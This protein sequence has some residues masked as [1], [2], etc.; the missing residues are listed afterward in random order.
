M[1]I[2]NLAQFL[3]LVSGRLMC[4]P[5]VSQQ[6]G[7]ANPQPRPELAAEYNF[8]NS[9]APPGGCGC[10]N[11]NGGS[12]TFAWPLGAGSFSLLGDVGVSHAGSITSSGYGLTLSTFTVG[13]RYALRLAHSRFLPYGQ[14][15]AGVAHA[16]GTL[17]AGSNPGATNAG[18]AF[19]GIAGGGVDF[20]ASRRISLRLVEADY[21][22]TTF[23]NG[24]NDHQNNLRI[25]AGVV[26]SF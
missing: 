9:N 10:F 19:A 21:L 16:S 11:L 12:A 2:R 24:G 13:G 26:L 3:L 18:A 14:A 15:L 23:D 22:A 25:G 20:Q 6:A 8:L 5:A 1:R 7:N 17:V 4:D